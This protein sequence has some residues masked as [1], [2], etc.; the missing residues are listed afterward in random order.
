M[1]QQVLQTHQMQFILQVLACCYDEEN[2]HLNCYYLQTISMQFISHEFFMKKA[3]ISTT[4]VIYKR[5]L[6]FIFLL[7]ATKSVLI[8][9]AVC[10]AA[11][12]DFCST[13][14]VLGKK[15]EPFKRCQS[16]SQGHGN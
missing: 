14:L 3:L 13:L 9:T 10:H 11:L 6:F 2:A 16:Q 7:A 15:D 8:T 1:A 5:S 12:S 4:A